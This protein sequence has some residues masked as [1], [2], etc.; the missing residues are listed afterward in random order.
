MQRV[1]QNVPKSERIHS[2]NIEYL[3][4]NR[5]PEKEQTHASKTEAVGGYWQS[6]GSV[7]ED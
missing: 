3:R 1:A 6:G 2:K 4:T 7:A 5:T